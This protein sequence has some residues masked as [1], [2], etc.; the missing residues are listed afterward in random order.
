MTRIPF[1]KA[2]FAA[3]DETIADVQDRFVEHLRKLRSP[4]DDPP[5]E[6]AD[7]ESQQL[8]MAITRHN[9]RGRLPKA[10]VAKIKA[11]A[12]RIVAARAAASGLSHLKPDEVERLSVLR[13]GVRL[14]AIQSEDQADEI[15]AQLHQEMPWMA[16]A[17]ELVWHAMRRSAFDGEIGFRLP[18]MLLNGP[19]GIG[20]TRWATRLG[21]LLDVPSL[22][23]DASGEG[24][25]F[26]IAGLQ[27]GWGSAGPGRIL[28]TVLNSLTGNP[29]IIIDEV[30]KAGIQSSTKGSTH[31]L[32]DALLPLLERS[33]A[34]AW[35]CPYFRVT[36]DMSWLSFILLANNIDRLPDP[37]LSRCSVVNLPALSVNELRSFAK[38]EGSRRGLSEASL[39]AVDSALSA[40]EKMLGQASLRTVIRL[41]ER[42]EVLERRPM[43]S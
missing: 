11:R 13:Q 24:A 34:M 6:G 4:P 41:L 27:R 22:R 30:E 37:L 33:T 17:T 31:G 25:S 9:F 8:R 42:A 10:D 29:L 14:T 16:P 36:L 26:G 5:P 43:L 7:A 3:S 38:Q 2:S 32:T 20:K 1:I 19:P 21:E 35:S 28:E 12:G 23:I 40:T 15:A 18:P 39:A